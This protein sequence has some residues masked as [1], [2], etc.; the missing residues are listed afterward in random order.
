MASSDSAFELEP[1][2]PARRGSDPPAT[3]PR[4]AIASLGAW[5]SE[6]ATRWLF[7]WPTV[8]LILFVSIFPLIASATLSIS[9]LVFEKGAIRIDLVGPVN[10]A[11]VL[12][13]TE[14]PHFVGVLKT[15]TLV[16]W[17]ILLAGVAGVIWA[18][19]RSIRGGPCRAARAGRPAPRRPPGHRA[20]SRCS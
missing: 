5:R 16:G 20:T 1:E 13:G 12:L 11:I 6:G 9:H 19:T 17:A 18:F 8:L 14:Q 10:Y 3:Q 4:R 15:P 2:G 7:I